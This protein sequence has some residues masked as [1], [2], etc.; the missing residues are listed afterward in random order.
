MCFQEVR[1]FIRSPFFFGY[2]EIFNGA[3]RSDKALGS[4][5]TLTSVPPQ[6]ELLNEETHT[7]SRGD[8]E[9]TCQKSRSFIAGVGPGFLFFY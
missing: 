8:G 3:S 2:L 1:R 4:F 5:P 7:H 9:K 6:S